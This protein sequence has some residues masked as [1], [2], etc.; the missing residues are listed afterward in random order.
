MWETVVSRNKFMVIGTGDMQ[1][2]LARFGP[3]QSPTHF[4]AVFCATLGTMG[5]RD[6]A[7]PKIVRTVHKSSGHDL[8]LEDEVPVDDGAQRYSHCYLCHSSAVQ[9]EF[10]Q[11]F[12]EPDFS[13]PAKIL[14]DV[15]EMTIMPE[16]CHSLIICKYCNTLCAEYQSLIER[17]EAIHNQITTAYNQ[18]VMKLA[19][20]TEKDIKDGLVA[21]EYDDNLETE[22]QTFNK[23]LMSME[24]VFGVDELNP[25]IIQVDSSAEHLQDPAVDL[26]QLETDEVVEHSLQ[27]IS[28]DKDATVLLPEDS[29]TIVEKSICTEELSG[30]E[31]L[32]RIIIGSDETIVEVDAEDGTSIY[33]VYGD[34]I[35][36][37]SEPEDQPETVET[38]LNSVSADSISHE[39]DV[40]V[41]NASQVSE[42]DVLAI[43]ESVSGTSL[44]LKE[45]DG[46]EAET[47]SQSEGDNLRPEWPSS[48]YSVALGSISQTRSF[49]YPH[50]DTPADGRLLRFDPIERG[51]G[52]KWVPTNT[53]SSASS[54][55]MG[56]I[57]TYIGIDLYSSF[58]QMVIWEKIFNT[59]PTT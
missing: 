10:C 9:D 41:E 43:E 55:Q 39:Q 34:G 57:I 12:T 11:L 33:C 18:T 17:M 5:S 4:V 53:I 38:M 59:M 48:C 51:F 22:L 25:D 54:I 58:R 15:L 36:T 50:E 49:K 47:T 46:T 19:G 2:C 8:A 29:D 45:V 30:D 24:E 52:C 35:E 31:T 6:D 16:V 26:H 14:G 3:A 1:T 32:Q 20:L 40:A 27:F 13:S 42:N 7:S 21:V 37:F 44:L 28:A 23:E 56:I